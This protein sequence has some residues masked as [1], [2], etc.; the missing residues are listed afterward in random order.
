MQTPDI[1]T[2]HGKGSVPQEMLHS[3]LITFVTALCRD[4]KYYY[5]CFV[6]MI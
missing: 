6:F 3:V 1:I 2:I 5:R 4:K